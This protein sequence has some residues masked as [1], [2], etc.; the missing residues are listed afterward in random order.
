MSA[1][2]KNNCTKKD[3]N[4]PP[5]YID[6]ILDFFVI[7]HLDP[8]SNEF[9]L[10]P[11]LHKIILPDN[12]LETEWNYGNIYV[13]PPYGRD[14]ESKT[15]IYNWIEKG[16]VS[17]EKFNSELLYLIPV[18]TNTK[19]FKELIFKN[20]SCICFL[21]DTRLKF[22]NNGQEDIKGAPMACCMCY[23]GD[24]NNKFIEIF[25]EYGKCFNI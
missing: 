9:S 16:I 3:W 10:V 21:N 23:L 13:N 14:K 8:C 6:A 18:A 7:I 11:A 4:T 5:K 17:N 15:S 20:F 2:R 22:Y 24:K 1:G 25:S 19:H 12:G